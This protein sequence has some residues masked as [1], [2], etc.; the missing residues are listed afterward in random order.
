MLVVVAYDIPDS[1]R[2][3]KLS[4]FLEGY[5]RRVQR[6]VFEC[7]LSLDEM[8]KLHGQLAKRVVPAEDDVR[9]YWINADAVP[10]TLTLGSAPPEPP[11]DAYIL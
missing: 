2:R 9:L 5:G 3:K 4:D 8:T 1:K 7:F 6:S 10:R 11:P